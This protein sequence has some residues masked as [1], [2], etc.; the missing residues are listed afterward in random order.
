MKNPIKCESTTLDA[1]NLDFVVRVL[2]YASQDQGGWRARV[3]SI[4]FC[5]NPDR[6]RPVLSVEML[7]RIV[8]KVKMNSINLAKSMKLF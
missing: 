7:D 8:L 5:G 3:K 2:K 1:T 4:E 6:V